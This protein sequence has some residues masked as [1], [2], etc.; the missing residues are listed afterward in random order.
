M[1]NRGFS[2]MELM[3]VVAIIMILG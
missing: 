1:K 3:I 2:L